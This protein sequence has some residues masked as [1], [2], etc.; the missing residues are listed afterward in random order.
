MIFIANILELNG[1]TT[2]LI[3]TCAALR[4]AGRQC[5]VL[6]LRPGGDAKLAEELARHARVFPLAAFQI[7]RARL[8]KQQIGILG[9]ISWVRMAET[10]APFGP[11]VHAMGAFGLIAGARLARHASTY[12]VTAGVY[13]QNE[14]LFRPTR[15]FSA[16]ILSLF[17]Q[18]P[19]EN[20]LFFNEVSRDNYI[21]FHAQPDYVRSP[22]APIGINI[23]PA[24]QVPR[25]LGGQRIV[26]IGNF[27][28]FKTY[29]TQVIGLLPKLSLDFPD[30][31]YHLY[32]GGEMREALEAQTRALRVETRVTFHGQISYDRLPEVWDQTDIFVGSGTALIEAAAAGLPALVGV[33]SLEQPLTYGFLSDIEGLSYNELS[34]HIPLC[35]MNTC[36]SSVLGDAYQWRVTADAC[37]AKA[38]E[39]SVGRTAQVL[40]D[41][42]DSAAPTPRLISKMTVVRMLAGVPALVL[43]DRLSPESAFGLRRNQSFEVKA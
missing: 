35:P 36:I 19:A 20:V 29:N 41:L 8:F 14:F 42:I 33:E 39:F 1:G 5:A 30:I 16:A 34:P 4:R 26:S 2:F 15:Y 7:D 10:L 43:G 17:R 28:R 31:H 37:A 25:R 13:H 27:E 9:P 40:L 32:G 18:V 11:V 21:S 24:P 38:Q 23:P 12:R 3:R 6:V 22:I